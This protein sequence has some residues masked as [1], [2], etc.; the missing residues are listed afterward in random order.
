[1]LV[2]AQHRKFS[3]IGSGG[4]MESFHDFHEIGLP[5]RTLI[6]SL[7]MVKLIKTIHFDQ[8]TGNL[9]DVPG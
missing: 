1:M 9:R 7:V 4:I 5:A 3:M 8:C 6:F 2:T